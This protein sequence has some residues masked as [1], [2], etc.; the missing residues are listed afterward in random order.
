[1]KRMSL[2]CML[3]ALGMACLAAAADLQI[4]T[5]TRW[6]Q[7]DPDLAADANGRGVI[8]WNSTRQDG[9]SGGIFARRIDPNGPTGPEFQVN[10]VAAGNQAEPS[11]A[12]NDL[13]VFMVVWRGPW[14]GSDAE[15]IVA[16]VFDPNGQPM[17]E[18]LH[19]NTHAAARQG[20]ARVAAGAAGRF[21]VV[22]ESDSAPDVNH[23]CI[24]GQLI[25]QT[26]H[27][28]GPE[29]AVSDTPSY[30]ARYP[31]VAID[32]QGRVAVSWM[33]D[34]TT[35]A[36]RGRLFDADG[37]PKAASFK[38]NTISFKSL[39]WPSIAM[40]AEGSFVVAWDGDPKKS[41]DDDVHVRIYG[42]EGNP[43]GDEIQ[44]NA[45]SAGAQVNP[46]VAI[47]DQGEFIVVWTSPSGDPNHGTD[48][49]GQRFDAQG[50]RMGDESRLN[51]FTA[52][53]QGQ[54]DVTL[55]N[56][57][58]FLVVWESVG[59]D[60]SGSGISGMPGPRPLSAGLNSDGV[61]N[62]LDY[63]V[64]ASQWGKTGSGW[65]ADLVDNDAVDWTDVA[66]FSGQWLAHPAT[67]AS[68]D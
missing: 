27:P 34:R 25:D 4:N 60:G 63:E 66:A 57:G 5:T 19:I 12:V 37:K 30:A 36:V 24:R 40:N 11:A 38:V 3:A 43:A 67:D 39:T 26:G 41:S 50:Q 20:Y 45:T 42:A 62:F 54:P 64:L 59:Q 65:R 14:P 29:I 58:R 28:L 23:L 21:F 46:R 7:K 17:T 52:G 31:D 56:D 53:D 55:G 47:D 9:D 8:V 15:D 13:G 16:R 44:V 32:G 10:A 48:V 35:D 18:D 51:H 68:V 61:V 6:D 22:W 1:M 33:E 2:Q 49:M